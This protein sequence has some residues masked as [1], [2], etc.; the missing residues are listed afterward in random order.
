MKWLYIIIICFVVSGCAS[1]PKST[2]FPTETN[3]PKLISTATFRST[4]TDNPEPSAT[5][6]LQPTLTPTSWN[7]TCP[8]DMSIDGVYI[9]AGYGPDPRGGPDHLGFDIAGPKGTPIKSPYSCH[10]KEVFIGI[11]GANVLWLI[12]A[13]IEGFLDFGHMDFRLN[14]YDALKWWGIPIDTFYNPDGTVK[15]MPAGE[16]LISAH[17]VKNDSYLQ[18]EPLH[19]YM[20]STG[21]SGLNHLNVSWWILKN[22]AYDEHNDPEQIIKCRQ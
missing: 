12:C 22:G 8:V 19:V 11:D 6:T 21:H 5:V 2:P 4:Q 14:D 7:S 13:G 16:T 15:P 3:T 1:L 20:A 10:V 18:G 17:P 9:Y